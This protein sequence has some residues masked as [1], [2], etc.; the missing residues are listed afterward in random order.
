MFSIFKRSEVMFVPYQLSGMPF[1][2]IGQPSVARH[3]TQR[4]LVMPWS[5]VCPHGLPSIFGFLWNGKSS[6][7]SYPFGFL[8]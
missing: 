2:H 7:E 3:M 4:D 5:C 8:G 1:Q 6:P